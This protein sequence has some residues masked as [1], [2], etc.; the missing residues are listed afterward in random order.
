MLDS[1]EFALEGGTS[2]TFPGGSAGVGG[3]GGS[4]MGGTSIGG[5]AGSVPVGG[6]G[7][8]G[9][10]GGFP[11]KG[12]T[13]GSSGGST[14]MLLGLWHFDDCR[15]NNL[16]LDD[17]SGNG[18]EAVRSA[19]T[20]CGIGPGDDGT[21]VRDAVQFNEAADVVTVANEPAFELD[22]NLFVSAWIRPNNV[23]QTQVVAQKA[24]AN[25]Q[26][27]T[28]AVK[29][30]RI[31]FT[32]QLR[33]GQVVTS[34]APVKAD[35]WTQV[36]GLFD[37]SFIFLFVDG[38][39]V[40]QV[41]ARG[42]LR[43]VNGPLRIG[44]GVSGTDFFRGRIDEVRFSS[45]PLG[46]FDVAQF[47][48]L[49]RPPEL[50]SIVPPT[51]GPV[52]PETRVAYDVSVRNKN[53]GEACGFGEFGLFLDFLPEGFSFEGENFMFIEQGTTG[54]FPMALTGTLDAEPGT[55]EIPFTVFDFFQGGS[56]SGALVYEL[57]EPTG[58]FVRTSRELMITT[59]SV[60]DDPV[61][62]T[63]DNPGDPNNG[64]WTFGRLMRDMAPSEAEAEAFV[65]SMFETWRTD[66]TVNG[67]TIPARPAIDPQLLDAWPR[68]PNGELDLDRSPLTLQAIVNRI[69]T[70]S[71][72]QGNAGEGRFVF[73]VNQ[74][75]DTFPQEFTV[76]LEYDLPAE[77]EADVLEWAALWHGLGS[78]PFPSEEYNAALQ[79]VTDRFSRRGAAPDRVNGSA[80]SQ[81]RSNEIALSFRW[82]LRE[83]GLSPTT[84][85]LEPATVKLTPDNS[86]NFTSILSDFVN[87]NEG[88]ILIERHDVP[89][90][91][92]GVPFLAGSSFNDLVPWFGDGSIVNNDAR[93]KFSI[94]TCNGCHGPEAGVS[95]LQISPRFFQGEPAF[96]SGFLT[97]TTV[98]DPVTDEPR[99]IND[100]RR[101]RLD[102]EMLVCET[103]AST[104]TQRISAAPGAPTIA[105]GI[106]RVH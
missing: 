75:F 37:G 42:R 96:L 60:V 59:P 68:L 63:F 71:L 53:F 32:V 97:G 47:A 98:F 48:C 41:S 27:F 50:V 70:R 5:T 104:E 69:D 106:R 15:N 45:E 83:F 9:S 57:L 86:F 6:T 93:H 78:L 82:E 51:S 44:N 79:A 80:I 25:N 61:R 84:G 4:S 29:N 73:A 40:G 49:S 28:L 95:F 8:G 7:T 65:R 2:G 24:A 23:Q 99:E 17:S 56:T 38:A 103:A 67:F 52:Q 31:E 26:S 20:Q 92:Q 100:L 12:G 33:N 90:E 64:A 77:T 101:R 3:R 72:S 89:N 74:P 102:L 10:M 81:V 19:S 39:R 30:K 105:E 62:T 34:S 94:N 14:G 11:G 46:E 1:Q 85:F 91:F 76:I 55:H 13:G 16:V 22:Q 88:S 66:Q 43:N 54:V 35:R 87:E 36:A 58:C 21:T 18:F